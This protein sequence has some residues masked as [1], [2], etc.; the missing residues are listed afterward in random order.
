MSHV[1]QWDTESRLEREERLRREARIR[2][3]IRW[4]E[5]KRKQLLV[6]DYYKNYGC[7]LG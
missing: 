6:N 3:G 5:Y 7:Y 4:A 2:L 1:Y